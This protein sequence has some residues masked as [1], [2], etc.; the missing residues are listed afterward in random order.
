MGAGVGQAPWKVWGE[1]CI[2]DTAGSKWKSPVAPQR[3]GFS[4]IRKGFLAVCLFA[5]PSPSLNNGG[6]REDVQGPPAKYLRQLEPL[7][8]EGS[9]EGTH[10]LGLRCQVL[11][12]LLLGPGEGPLLC[13]V[14]LWIAS[15]HVC[16]ASHTG[17]LL[18]RL[19]LST[20][21]SQPQLL[22]LIPHPPVP[23]SPSLILQ[24]A[25]P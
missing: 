3:N 14:G 5:H 20:V 18:E 7:S 24:E 22:H 10:Q 13:P 16:W 11:T 4:A 2:S 17:A 8:R 9:V 19:G 23:H 1:G 21:G 6:N 25:G 15:P 12:D